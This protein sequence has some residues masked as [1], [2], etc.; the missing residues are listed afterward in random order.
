[1]CSLYEGF[2]AVIYSGL[3]TLKIFRKLEKT[4]TKTPTNIIFLLT[5]SPPAF[6]VKI[7]KDDFKIEI[8]KNVNDPKDLENID[9]DGYLAMPTEILYKGA[10]GIKNG[11]DEKKVIIKN[12]ESLT[13]LAKITGLE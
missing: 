13:I 9:C 4:F 12:F 5:D 7:D 10:V 3:W 6:L 8:L 11:I 2:P 1:M